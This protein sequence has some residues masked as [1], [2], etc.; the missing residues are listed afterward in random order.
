MHKP[1]YDWHYFIFLIFFFKSNG[2]DISIIFLTASLVFWS[3]GIIF[4]Y[5]EFGQ[6]LSESFEDIGNKIGRFKWYS[7]PI[8]IKRMLPIIIMNV[9]EPV[10]ITAFG[11][12]SCSRDTF[13]KVSLDL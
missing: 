11:S 1:T 5:C 4:F 12:I 10:E 7:F 9:H 2:G 3:L 13:K 6:R 8:G